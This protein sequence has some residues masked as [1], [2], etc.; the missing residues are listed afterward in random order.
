MDPLLEMIAKYMGMMGQPNPNIPQQNRPGV[1]IPYQQG[2]KTY[3]DAQGREIPI[4]PESNVYPQGYGRPGSGQPASPVATQN[5]Y[6]WERMERNDDQ[7]QLM[8]GLPRNRSE[9]PKHN[10]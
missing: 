4:K 8:S 3:I 7:N 9:R 6:D 1:A 10:K 2:F 5:V